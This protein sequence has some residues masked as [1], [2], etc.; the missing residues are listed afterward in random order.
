M[1]EKK[2]IQRTPK[3][4]GNLVEN[5]S[6]QASSNWRKKESPIIDSEKIVPNTSNSN[7]LT[8]QKDSKNFFLTP[9]YN[10]LTPPKSSKN[11]FLTP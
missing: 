5:T 2:L 10:F 6:T 1:L 4:I 8:P 11:F 7:F 3:K 9:N